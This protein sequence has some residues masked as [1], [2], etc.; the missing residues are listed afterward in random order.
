MHTCRSEKTP[1]KKR[2]RS[3]IKPFQMKDRSHPQKPFSIETNLHK[4]ME[5]ESE[6]APVFSPLPLRKE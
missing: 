2:T 6:L 5:H 3:F 1:E 4:K